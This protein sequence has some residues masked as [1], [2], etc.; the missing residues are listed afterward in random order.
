MA[1]KTGTP[2]ALLLALG[3]AAAP[4]CAPAPGGPLPELTGELNLHRSPYMDAWMDPAIAAF[5]EKFPEVQVNVEDHNLDNW[6]ADIPGVQT[7]LMSGQGPFLIYRP[8]YFFPDIQKTMSTGVFADL[9]PYFAADPE[10]SLE[11]LEASVLNVG[12]SKGMQNHRQP[13]PCRSH[14]QRR[15]PAERLGIYE[16]PP[17]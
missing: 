10:I 6:G 16:D 12:Q 2:L 8:E 5:Q 1:P 14:P 9:K 3:L 15:Q 17:F 7:S 4:G 11:E 13:V